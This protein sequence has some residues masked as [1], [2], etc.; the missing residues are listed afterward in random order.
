MI[1]RFRLA[2]IA[3]AIGALTAVQAHASVPII[4]TFACPLE[5]GGGRSYCLVDYVSTGATTVT[6]SGYGTVINEPGR[7]DSYRHCSINDDF[8]ATVTMTNASGSVTRSSAA[9]AARAGRSFSD[10][11]TSDVADTGVHA[12][13]SPLALERL[14][15]ARTGKPSPKTMHTP[16]IGDSANLRTSFLCRSSQKFRFST[17]SQTTAARIDGRRPPKRPSMGGHMEI[18]E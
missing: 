4:A 14:V 9:R 10:T 18:Q 6:W 1:E 16:P 17:A 15:R 5:K 12:G 8:T 2:G 13:V 11:S 7:S 3:G